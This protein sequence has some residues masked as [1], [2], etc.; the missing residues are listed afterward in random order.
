MLASSKIAA[1]RNIAL[2]HFAVFAK[3]EMEKLERKNIMVSSRLHGRR[4]RSE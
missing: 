1:N 4:I 2:F 3:K